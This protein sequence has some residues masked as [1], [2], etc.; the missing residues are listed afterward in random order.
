MHVIDR[1]G[2]GAL[3]AFGCLAAHAEH[4]DRTKDIQVQASDA[5]ADQRQ[6]TA[7]FSG[8]VVVSQGTLEIRA[9]RVLM[10]AGRDGER[11]VSRVSVAPTPPEMATEASPTP[12]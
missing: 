3:L 5:R 6:Q 4:A 7:E 2:V 11:G 12:R 1:L 8:D 9:D 10:R